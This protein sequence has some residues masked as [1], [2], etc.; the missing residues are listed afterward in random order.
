MLEEI[1]EIHENW[2]HNKVYIFDCIEFWN[3]NKSHFVIC[4][5]FGTYRQ[6]LE[7][8]Q[9]VVVGVVIWSERCALLI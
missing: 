3:L 8:K 4:A 9:A 7:G 5:S 2:S 6:D 1:E